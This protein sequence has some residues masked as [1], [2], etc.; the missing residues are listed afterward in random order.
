MS[1]TTGF[2]LVLLGIAVLVAG[3]GVPTARISARGGPLYLDGDISANQGGV[4][5]VQ[6]KGSTDELGLDDP[7]VAFQPK[8]ELDWGGW[9]FSLDGYNA[10][11][12]GDG[13]A[14]VGLQ[15]GNQ[16]PVEAGAAV[17]SELDLTYVM[18]KA[19]Y[20]FVPGDWLDLGI[21]LGGGVL[22][23]D[24]SVEEIFGVGTF[25]T[26]QAVPVIYPVIRA[27]TLLGPVRIAGYL[28]AIGLTYNGD[29]VRFIDG[30]IYAGLRVF[31]EESRVQGWVSV[32]YRYMD[33]L[34][35]YNSRGTDI[36]LDATVHGP[37]LS[38]EITF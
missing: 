10:A 24:F 34:L 35:E 11:W 31:G 27:G 25:K 4:V 21:G 29:K 14:S 32:G 5:N 33:V 36:D 28:G 22:D 15:I 30:E 20:D 2:F 7:E 18:L 26:A 17:S 19:T 9:N 37:Y 6:G 3:C 12:S 13:V 1:R 23:Y 16:P 38:L 8:A